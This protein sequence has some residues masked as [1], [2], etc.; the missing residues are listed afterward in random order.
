MSVGVAG[1]VAD[2]IQVA[3]SQLAAWM[4][5]DYKLNDSE[6]AILTGTALEYDICQLVDP[7]FSVVAKL[8][9]RAL[10]MLN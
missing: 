10:A 9:K 3:T 5:R 6:I 2:A 4:K 7:H 1:S 8:P